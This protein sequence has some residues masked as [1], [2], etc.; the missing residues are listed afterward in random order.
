[1]LRLHSSHCLP[2]HVDCEKHA[3]PVLAAVFHDAGCS[4]CLETLRHSLSHRCSCQQQTVPDLKC[5]CVSALQCLGTMHG[6]HAIAAF[7]GLM[8]AYAPGKTGERNTYS[9]IVLNSINL[10]VATR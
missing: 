3:S 4:L 7:L 6:L 9:I 5:P 1:M 2:G 10:A 8:K